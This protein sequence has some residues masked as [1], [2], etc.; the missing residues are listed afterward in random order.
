MHGKHA[1]DATKG[2]IAVDD[3]PAQA[4][5]GSYDSRLEAIQFPQTA[6]LELDKLLEQLVERAHDVQETQGRL[7]GLLDAYRQVTS[8]VDLETVLGHIVEAARQLVNARYAALGVVRENQLV[9]FLHTGMAADTVA[10]IG[11]LPEGKGVL[12]LLVNYPQTL[13]LPDIAEHPA[14]VGFPEHHP[15]MHSFL[16]VPILAGDRIF[17]NLYLADKQ[18]APE[19]TL[20]DEKLVT[21]LAGVAGSAI[22]NATLF[23]ET[24]RRQRWQA[25][26]TDI[27]TILLAAES[28]PEDALRR[29]VRH[30]AEAAGAAGMGVCLPT[31]DPQALRLTIAE[32]ILARW[33]DEL[34]PVRGSVSG[35]A[36]IERQLVVVDDPSADPRNRVAATDTFG[37]VGQTMAVPMIGNDDVLGVLV[38]ARHPGDT[39][40]DLLDR[41][42]FAASAAQAGLAL[43]LAEGRRYSELLRLAQEREH[44]A[45][46]LRHQVIQ[47]LFAHGLTLQSAALRAAGPQTRA[48]IEAQIIEVDAIIRD[49][50]SAV[51]NLS[52]DETGQLGTNGL[53]GMGSLGHV[54]EGK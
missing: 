47:R 12:G 41:D 50:R 3:Q 27:T 46:E 18:G 36:A 20:D 32:G 51:F 8:A 49:I 38:A 4:G 34:V 10:A 25:T 19:F 37:V 28:D 30:V 42:L 6:R 23:E 52:R 48:D 22:E 15:P 39:A 44:I 54:S 53:Q 13:R 14:S 2:V 17:G 1:R 7:R 9:R 31:D 29:L 33:Q 21:A 16:G 5:T 45:E 43:K 40:F 24:R 26:M 11:H 35:T